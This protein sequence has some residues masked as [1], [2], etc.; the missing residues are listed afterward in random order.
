MNERNIESVPYIKVKGGDLKEFVLFK[1]NIKIRIIV[2]Q[3]KNEKYSLAL[4]LMNSW[5]I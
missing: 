5:V 2:K 3:N 4:I 1:E